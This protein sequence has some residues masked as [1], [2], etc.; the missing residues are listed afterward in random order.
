MKRR[1][2]KSILHV[3]YG[4]GWTAICEENKA[5][6]LPNGAAEWVE[7][8]ELPPI[9]EPLG[10]V[11]SEVRGYLIPSAFV[12]HPNKVEMAAL[13]HLK[14]EPGV[15]QKCQPG[16]LIAISPAPA[17]E[18]P[19]EREGWLH[20]NGGWCWYHH[21]ASLVCRDRWHKVIPCVDFQVEDD[22]GWLLP[23]YAIPVI[24]AL[25]GGQV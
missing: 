7:L 2:F 4:C 3:A 6:H 22:D 11:Q 25:E 10:L 21:G 9:E 1:P 20:P 8:P 14:I 24:P 16:E 15:V 12:V 5:W 18:R 19:W 23:H 17:N 13:E